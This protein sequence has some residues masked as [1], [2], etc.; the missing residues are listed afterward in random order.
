MN[1]N[2]AKL[3][4]IALAITTVS[5]VILSGVW[6][7]ADQRTQPRVAAEVSDDEPSG[8]ETLKALRPDSPAEVEGA[9]GTSRRVD[10][11]ALTST[12]DVEFEQADDYG[13]LLPRAIAAAASGDGRAAFTIAR[14]NVACAATYALVPR[15]AP[16]VSRTDLEAAFEARQNARSVQ[17]VNG[18]VAARQ[19]KKFE[20]CASIVTSG[21]YASLPGGKGDYYS[22][23]YW[24]EE[25]IRL[26]DPGAMA[27]ALPRV[28]SAAAELGDGDPARKEKVVRAESY[29]R[30]VVHSGEPSALFSLG[31]TLV[32]N[33]YSDKPERG[34]VLSVAACELGLDCSDVAA[35]VP[36]NVCADMPEVCGPPIS[37]QDVLVRDVGSRQ[38]ARIYADAQ[39]VVDNVRRQDWSALTSYTQLDGTLRASP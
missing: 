19:R 12:W 29:M 35:L 31:A 7:L 14:V 3:S 28:L 30:N 6:L 2:E 39:R 10:T 5:A 11:G 21:I 26:G 20:R 4:S 17:G 22:F 16:T 34:L 37:Y 38:Y 33:R 9:T 24:S 32:N 36:S 15:E 23:A 27:D 1:W 18:R 25:A 8:R 13:K